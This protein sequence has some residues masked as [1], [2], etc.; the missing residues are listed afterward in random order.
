MQ[1]STYVCNMRNYCFNSFG[2]S[3]KKHFYNIPSLTCRK[4]ITTT[5]KNGW[6]KLLTYVNKILCKQTTNSDKY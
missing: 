4:D 3:E 2:L 6:N 1:S 5:I